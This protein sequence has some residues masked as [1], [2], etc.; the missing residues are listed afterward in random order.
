MYTTVHEQGQHAKFGYC[1]N[2]EAIEFR[3]N[4]RLLLTVL[5]DYNFYKN[6]TYIK[7]MF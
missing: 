5:F 2:N 7:F 3:C 4:V 6:K 1:H